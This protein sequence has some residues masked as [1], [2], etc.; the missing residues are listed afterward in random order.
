[1]TPEELHND[2]LYLTYIIAERN[3][4]TMYGSICVD[5]NAKRMRYFVVSIIPDTEH[6]YGDSS[7]HHSGGSS[8]KSAGTQAQSRW[9]CL[10]FD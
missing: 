9:I 7:H 3:P 10:R 8:S 5:D 2:M 1:M 4:D 6:P